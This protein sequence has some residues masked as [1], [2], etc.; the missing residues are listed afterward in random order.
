LNSRLFGKYSGDK[1]I[2]KAFEVVQWL[3][4]EKGKR[5]FFISNSSGKTR[6]EFLTKMG[7]LGYTPEPSVVIVVSD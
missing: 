6:S 5:V 4:K 2:D 1:E 7:K 3:I